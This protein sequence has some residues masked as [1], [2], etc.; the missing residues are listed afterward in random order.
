ML[1]RYR[2]RIGS[3]DEEPRQVDLLMGAKIGAFAFPGFF[4]ALG[5]PPFSSGATH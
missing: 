3:R 2:S 4:I 1:V 5:P